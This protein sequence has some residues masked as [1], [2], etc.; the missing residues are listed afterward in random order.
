MIAHPTCHGGYNRVIWVNSIVEAFAMGSTIQRTRWLVGR[1]RKRGMSRAQSTASLHQLMGQGSDLVQNVESLSR[2]INCS[3]L[4]QVRYCGIFAAVWKW[5]Y[6]APNTLR[7]SS[8]RR[9][10]QGNPIPEGFKPN[11]PSLPCPFST[12]DP[13]KIFPGGGL[14]SSFESVR[15]LRRF[16]LPSR[17]PLLAIPG[18]GPTLF[19]LSGS[20]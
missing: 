9:V 12:R 5:A 4:R 13:S 7:S 14:K 15:P 16:F 1:C 10:G 19:G 6:Y 20:S 2:G 11:S 3:F 8:W 18:I 17:L